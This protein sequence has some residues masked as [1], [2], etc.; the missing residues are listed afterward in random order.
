MVMV[1]LLM[2]IL[3]M[4]IRLMVILILVII[5]TGCGVYQYIS[6]TLAPAPHFT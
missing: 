5:T 2:V 4:V 1:I 6:M 3:L